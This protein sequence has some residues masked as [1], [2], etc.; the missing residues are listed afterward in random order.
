MGAKSA[1]KEVYLFLDQ[2]KDEEI[3][4]QAVMHGRD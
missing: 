3:G 4:K 2:L 1:L